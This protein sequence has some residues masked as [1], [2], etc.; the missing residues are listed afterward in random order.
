MLECRDGNKCYIDQTKQYLKKRIHN[1][2]CTASHK[3]TLESTLSKYFKDRWH[4]VDFKYRIEVFR[5]DNSYVMRMNLC[6][7]PCVS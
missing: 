5:K 7:A 3:V 6:D 2:E 4:N 1:H